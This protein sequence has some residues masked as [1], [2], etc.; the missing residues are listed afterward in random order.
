VPPVPAHLKPVAAALCEPL[1]D[2]GQLPA[3]YSEIAQRTGLPVGKRMRNLVA[4]LCRRYVSE[5]PQLRQR[6]IERRQR[7][8]AELSLPADP[9]LLH[10]VWNFDARHLE[11]AGEPAEVRRRRALALPDYYEVAHLLVR[12]RLVTTMDIA[13]LLPPKNGATA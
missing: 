3:T 1:L 4:E 5:V 7:E 6:I 10:G 2:G 13:A 8:E 11:A 12:R 9:T